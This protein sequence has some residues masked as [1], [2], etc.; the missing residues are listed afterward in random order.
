MRR[1]LWFLAFIFV[2][3]IGAF[4]AAPGEKADVLFHEVQNRWTEDGL[5]GLGEGAAD[6]SIAGLFMDRVRELGAYVDA[7]IDEEMATIDKIQSGEIQIGGGAKTMPAPPPTRTDASPG[8]PDIVKAEPSVASTSAVAASPPQHVPA[9]AAPDARM[10]A[11]RTVAPQTGSTQT[12]GTQQTPQT[13]DMFSSIVSQ[14]DRPDQAA[15]TEF[16]TE[17][18]IQEAIENGEPTSGGK[19]ACLFACD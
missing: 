5:S 16:W 8:A 2:A 15:R 19:R 3:L 7:R 13:E 18:R 6:G 12:G 11:P 9:Q 17:E 1:F 10:S 4:I 14:Q